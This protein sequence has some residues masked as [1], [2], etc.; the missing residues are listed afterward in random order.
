MTGQTAPQRDPAALERATERLAAVLVQSGWARMPALVYSAL[1]STDEGGLTSAGLTEAL[2]I[3]PAAVSGAVRYL[4]DL[5]LVRRERQA[6]SRREWYRLQENNWHEI[7]ERGIQGITRTEEA[8]RESLEAFG[9][10]TP[11]G[12]R[13]AGALD[14]YAFYRRHVSAVLRKWDQRAAE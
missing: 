5:G 6:G 10:D 14:F 13:V 3:S 8:L 1:L 11:A 4:D 9:E 7:I 2:G 12:R